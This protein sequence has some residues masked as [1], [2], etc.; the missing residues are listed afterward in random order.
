MRS[1]P[2]DGATPPETPPTADGTDDVERPGTP[3][4]TADRVPSG[5]TGLRLSRIWQV[6]AGFA[7]LVGLL[8]GVVALLD[9]FT[10]PAPTP[11]PVPTAAPTPRP[12]TPTITEDISSATG[13]QRFVDFAEA[14]SGQRVRLDLSCFETV[15]KPACI[16]EPSDIEFDVPW[17]WL[18]VFTGE[19]CFAPA[20]D[21]DPALR[22]LSRCADTALF[23]IDPRVGDAPVVLGNIQGAGTTA[24]KGP[25]DLQSPMGGAIFPG[26]IHGYSLVPARATPLE[27]VPAG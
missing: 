26:N 2:G 27:S 23:W 14:A 10:G 16:L 24:I 8:T 11:T 3:A 15:A 5:G 6:V 1:D 17:D 7:V 12:T 4:E 13:A 22:D 20:V 25:W 19:P 21:M 9:R 18:W